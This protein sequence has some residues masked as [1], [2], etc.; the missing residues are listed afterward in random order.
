MVLVSMY[1]QSIHGIILL[2]KAGIVRGLQE[3]FQGPNITKASGY[4]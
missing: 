3:Y 1:S 2:K 4:V